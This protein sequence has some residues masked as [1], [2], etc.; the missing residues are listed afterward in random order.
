VAEL[1][2][3]LVRDALAGDRRALAAFVGEMTPVIQVRVVRALLRRRASADGRDIRQE[4][5]DL[6][7]DV[8]GALF[9]HGGRAL[10]AWDPDRGLSLANF[11]GLI[12]DRH[13]ASTLR[14]GRKNPWRDRPQELDELESAAPPVTSAE[15]QVASRRALERLLDR[16]REALSPRGLELF[17]R[18]Y[19]EQEPIDE[20]AA[21]MGMTREAIYAWRN[22]VGKLLRSFSQEIAEEGDHAPLDQAGRSRK[23]EGTPTDG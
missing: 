13:A 23:P 8:F 15:P 14:S 6:T 21:A 11:V 16:M 19:V 10:R 5:E 1:A 9:A 20:V 12:A 4:V 2:I 22:R 3:A 18:L 7:Q 17:Q